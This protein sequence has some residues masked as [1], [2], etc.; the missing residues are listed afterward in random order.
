LS[1]RERG[2]KLF[3]L[4]E[5]SDRL[6]LSFLLIDC[7]NSPVIVCHSTQSH[8]EDTVSPLEVYAGN[9]EVT[10]KRVEVE[11]IVLDAV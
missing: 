11:I 5:E 2:S 3:G 4:C 6:A 7:S 8:A 10:L 1:R 9:S